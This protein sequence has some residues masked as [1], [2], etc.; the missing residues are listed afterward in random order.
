MIYV[1]GCSFTYGLGVDRKYAIGNQLNAD[2]DLSRAGKSN[3]AMVTDL[4]ENINRFDTFVIGFT[5][6]NRYTFY[7]NSDPVDIN[8]S[9]KFLDNLVDNPY[10]AEL[11]T[12]WD[13][14]SKFLFSLTNE[15]K[16]NSLSDFCLAATLELLKDKKHVVYSIQR[17]NVVGDYFVIPNLPKLTDGHFTEDGMLQLGKLIKE[18]L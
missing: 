2:L 11:E 6:P 18:K 15:E 12:N 16:M 13:I 4:Y 3:I 8:P 14:I 17:R 7:N 1:D 10:G 9:K 5:F